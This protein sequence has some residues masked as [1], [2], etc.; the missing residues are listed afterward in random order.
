M[1]PTEQVERFGSLVPSWPWKSFPLPPRDALE[2][3]WGLHC[4]EINIEAFTALSKNYFLQAARRQ[5][6]E[7]TDS[8]SILEKRGFHKD[9][10][11]AMK[12]ALRELHQRLDFLNAQMTLLNAAYPPERSAFGERMQQAARDFEAAKLN[13]I[14]FADAASYSSMAA[15]MQIKNTAGTSY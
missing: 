10:K 14:H 9:R 15:S 7:V 11:R 5:Q 12:A 4:L 13:G 8:L 3:A 2:A 6:A 1:I